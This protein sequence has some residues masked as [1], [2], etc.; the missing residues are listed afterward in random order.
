M[1]ASDWCYRTR[2]S[3]DS[4]PNSISQPSQDRSWLTCSR[5][6]P[7]STRRERAPRVL[8]ER[9]MPTTTSG[10]LWTRQRGARRMAW[11][12][13]S[14]T[15]GLRTDVRRHTKR[16]CRRLA[17]ASHGLGASSR[18]SCKARSR[19]TG[20][21]GRHGAGPPGGGPVTAGKRHW[22]NASRRGAT[23]GCRRRS[24]CRVSSWWTLSTTTPAA[25]CQRYGFVRT[26]ESAPVLPPDERRSRQPSI[27]PL[28]GEMM[29]RRVRSARRRAPCDQGFA[30]AQ[31]LIWR[32]GEMTV[33]DRTAQRPKR[34]VASDEGGAGGV[35]TFD[36]PNV[37]GR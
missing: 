5:T 20:I 2:P 15:H 8:L 18:G 36:H 7:S 19:L 1:T 13:R 11:P 37:E 3:T 27:R 21:S 29:G 33:T 30:E 26:P 25:F 12:P 17:S 35:G 22:C 28:T 31:F 6:T 32:N 4:S 14:A 34:A 24:R 16:S 10:A 9:S 23:Q